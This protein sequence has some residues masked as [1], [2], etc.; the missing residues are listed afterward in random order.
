[1]SY[2]GYGGDRYGDSSSYRGRDSGG[3]GGGGFGGGGAC[4]HRLTP[5]RPVPVHP[6]PPPPRLP[7]HCELV[8]QVV[9]GKSWSCETL[10]ALAEGV[11]ISITC[12]WRSRTSVTFPSSKSESKSDHCMPLP[13][14][15]LEAPTTAVM[16]QPIIPYHGN[17]VTRQTGLRTT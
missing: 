17:T 7:F 5:V 2:G 6:P 14:L 16:F 11:M 1:M 8:N 3:F 13:T 15:S 10:Q 9:P 12:A 4:S